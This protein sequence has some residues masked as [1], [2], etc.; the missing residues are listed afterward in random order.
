[1]KLLK[2]IFKNPVFIKVLV[3]ELI[4]IGAFVSSLQAPYEKT[5]PPNACSVEGGDSDKPEFLPDG[6]LKVNGNGSDLIMEYKAISLPAGRYM[7]C[8]N[9]TGNDIRY[10]EDSVSM[11]SPTNGIYQ[12]WDIADWH[13]SLT[14]EVYVAKDGGDL[15]LKINYSGNGN[16]ILHSISFHE[17]GRLYRLLALLL[18]FLFIN[19]FCIIY[20]LKLPGY[21]E[22][23]KWKTFRIIVAVLSGIILFTSLPLFMDSIPEGDDLE[24]HLSRICCIAEEFTHKQ[25]PVRIYHSFNGGQGYPCSIFYGDIFLYIPALL[26]CLGI[27]VFKAY[28][29][30]LL[31]INV[32]TAI[33]SYV[34][35]KRIFNSTRAGLIG[36]AIYSCAP[37]RI[38]N[39]YFRAAIGESAAQTFIPLLIC[40]AYLLIK[41]EKSESKPWV[42]ICA[43]AT[44]LIQTHILT[45]QMCC[46][47]WVLFIIIFVKKLLDKWVVVQLLKSALTTILINLWFL[48][49]FL[50]YYT[51]TGIVGSEMEQLQPIGLYPLQVFSI[52]MTEQGKIIRQG[53]RGEMPLSVGAAILLGGILFVAVILHGNSKNS[54]YKKIAAGTGIMGGISLLMSTV[55]FPWDSTAAISD[56]FAKFTHA[57]QFTF[58]YLAPATALLSIFAVAAAELA[59]EQK[60]SIEWHA[61]I[62]SLFTAALLIPVSHFYTG[63]F[64]TVS[65][66]YVYM[67]PSASDRLYLPKSTN[68]SLFSH[69]YL[70]GDENLEYTILEEA[71]TAGVT[72]ISCENPLDRDI[73][74]TLPITWYENYKVYYED[75][76]VVPAGA[77]DNMNLTVIVPPMY[78]GNIQ[79][80]FVEPTLWRVCELISIVSLCVILVL[81][82]P[83]RTIF[84]HKK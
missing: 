54:T 81:I 12:F 69:T 62:I 59:L 55:Y 66:Q 43:G 9:Y 64:D 45:T 50:R 30:Y 24:F 41:K 1:M 53:V 33:L 36:A 60:D 76:T 16:F 84:S 10:K 47:I 68:P 34:S 82:S 4:I 20:V 51:T 56:A 6:S 28:Q 73:E 46:I 18:L 2:M 25:F 52:F 65:S 32:L 27:P 14:R 11:I 80:A 17:L 5:L 42:W 38:I 79:V 44:G 75:E 3:V 72:V 23:P 74:L 48:F 57:I 49:P 29:I 8:I 58:R 31:M 21:T 78:K 67:S 22:T 37:Y 61:I 63:F 40:G 7:V 70:S 39:M 19:A 77:G 83:L 13:Q 35:N 15:D 71:A 26:L